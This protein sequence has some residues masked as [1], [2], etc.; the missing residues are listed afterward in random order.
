MMNVG[1][2]KTYG[3]AAVAVIQNSG[4][5]CISS[6]ALPGHDHAT[7]PADHCRQPAYRSLA[8]HLSVGGRPRP[9]GRR[10]R[11]LRR[12]PNVLA[13]SSF[14]S[15]HRVTVLRSLLL[16]PALLALT[17]CGGGGGG[18]NG[19]GGG[20]GSNLPPVASI[21]ATP[22][23]G[24]CAAPCIIEFNGTGSSDSDGSIASY[25]WN[26]DDSSTA[27]TSTVR[28]TFTVDGAYDITLTV[29]DNSGANNT[30]HFALTVNSAGNTAPVAVI[31]SD[32]R[33][34]IIG[35][36][37][38][39]SVHFNAESST[40]ADG[41]NT[42]TAWHWDFGNDEISLIENPTVIYDTPGIY[43]VTLTVTDAAGASGWQ[44]V[45]VR[46][47]APADTFT[48][49]GSARLN[50]TLFS[51][52]DTADT[53]FHN[54]TVDAC[55]N[56][57]IGAQRLRAPS[58]T[59]GLV[60]VAPIGIAS[61]IDPIDKYRVT[62]AGG[63]TLTLSTSDY[64]IGADL[65]LSIYDS[66]DTTL[67]ASATEAA[68]ETLTVASAGEYVLH[69]T[70][71]NSGSNYVL[72]IGVAPSSTGHGGA[73]LPAAPAHPSV[74]DA[75]S[76][77][78][79]G[80]DVIPDEY[81]VHY[82]QLRTPWR[83]DAQAFVRSR[84]LAS[85]DLDV[86]A[87][88]EDR[89]LLL[90]ER[91]MNRNMNR[92]INHND[93]SDT[94]NVRHQR[95]R[96]L[97]ANADVAW[98][99]PNRRRQTFTDAND[100][101]FPLQW[102]LPLARFT[103][104]W[105]IDAL[106]GNGAIVAVIDTGILVD[107]PDFD[108]GA[109][110]V[111][112]YDF[113][114][115]SDNANDGDGRDNN[116]ADPGGGVGRSLFHGTHVAGIIA[117]R[118]EF[119][120]IGGNSGIAGAAPRVKIMPLRAFG[121]YGGSS[122]DIAAAIRYAAGLTNDSNQLP[123]TPADVINMSF[124]STGWAQVE[125]DAVTAARAAGA[126]L[127]A[128]AGNSNDSTPIYPA[129]YPGVVGVGAVAQNSQRAPYSSFG[130]HVDVV[131]PG[132]DTNADL[133]GNGY[134]DGI[135]GTVADDSAGILSI[136]YGYDFYQGTSMAAPH[137]SAVAALMK[138]LTVDNLNPLTPT[139]FDT[140]LASGALTR[141]LG[142]AG[143]DDEYGFGLI[144]AEKALAATSYASAT[145]ARAVATPSHLSVGPASTQAQL[146]LD[147]GGGGTL[148]LSSVTANVPWLAITEAQV[149]ATTKTGRYL[150]SLTGV[151]PATDG[152]YAATITVT[153]DGSNSPLLIP[154]TLTVD[155]ST[156]A[157][158]Q[159]PLYVILWDPKKTP[160]LDNPVTGMTVPELFADIAGNGAIVPFDL[161]LIA[162]D[163]FNDRSG[164]QLFIGSDMDND[165]QVCDPGEACG[166]WTSLAQP[167]IFR[168]VQD[169]TLNLDVGW[170]TALGTLSTH[171]TAT[172][173]AD[174]F[175]RR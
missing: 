162:A 86:V 39:F 161:G 46:I 172:I 143:R 150:V 158:V 147:N 19:G 12:L 139:Q 166:A 141:D 132:G 62:L 48:L 152:Q 149:N 6:I 61:Y 137:V 53:V 64:A 163:V 155:T 27:T 97:R 103:G 57:A 38:N 164:Y 74:A 41:N 83:F 87:G 59:G 171:G 40:D 68:T 92:N 131:A 102:N 4:F 65:D 31:Q 101:Y 148:T 25:A 156:P 98:A 140:L 71:T 119:T 165:G 117:A 123:A 115:D 90:R 3:A 122:Y 66:T 9:T 106:R 7:R 54:N 108:S 93:V 77:T 129:A 169:R 28:H 22:S 144:D 42:I 79:D 10:L 34:G 14:A 134:P 15:L 175:S 142:V 94:R 146:V 37:E 55:N 95:L 136:T 145:A 21:L 29:T 30:A 60:S 110:L 5:V 8:V 58:T 133:D 56:T 82:A 44:T 50:D 112:G 69:V 173:P 91:V 96:A 109:Q 160:G 121:R 88:N 63:E 35:S 2:K 23:G 167:Q 16:I 17:A 135:L 45:Q 105:E 43:N 168:H 120:P 154:L 174:G 67:I 70:A 159:M 81:I 1:A 153:H 33:E 118:T 111:P 157:T 76:N 104:A 85:L 24:S 32:L 113:I 107:H 138:A 75:N 170:T 89:P 36:G 124:G 26:F 126:I 20:G 84:E 80:D 99:E 100:T 128:A 52:C 13:M 47:A 130:A 72:N 18:S 49:D 151:P 11:V 116:P 51:D 114:G 127:V 73:L 125:Q 78:D